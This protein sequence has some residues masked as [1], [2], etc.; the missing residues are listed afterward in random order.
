MPSDFEIK[1]MAVSLW[2]LSLNHKVSNISGCL[3]SKLR[4]TNTKA[5][6]K[7]I[8]S[9][10]KAMLKNGQISREKFL[11]GRTLSVRTHPCPHC[12]HIEYRDTN[13]AKNILALA[14]KPSSASGKTKLK[15]LL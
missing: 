5:F 6:Q 13:G 8:H 10:L 11:K 3:A 4:V 12:G 15:G 7:H 14:L 2:L 1:R 9:R